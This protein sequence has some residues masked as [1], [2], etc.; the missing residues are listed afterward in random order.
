MENPHATYRPLTEQEIAQLERHG[1]GAEGG[2]WGRVQVAP[3]FDAARIRHVTFGGE[4]RIG[5]HAARGTGP[6]LAAGPAGVF[7][8]RLVN[9]TLGNHVRIANVGVR[10]ANYD[11]GDEACIENV[12][13]METSPARA[14][15]TAWR[16]TC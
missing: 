12:G 1:C 10:L 16:L 14:S 5:S 11:I 15:V 9:C 13:I 4:I 3:G 8:A 2:D 7:H 6:G